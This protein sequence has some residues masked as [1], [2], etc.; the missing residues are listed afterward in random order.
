MERGWFE[1]CPPLPKK[2][3]VKVLTP[4]LLGTWPFLEL[5]SSRTQSSEDG[6]L[7]ESAGP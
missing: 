3:C 6:I 1:L 5:G 4:R 2:R 7:L